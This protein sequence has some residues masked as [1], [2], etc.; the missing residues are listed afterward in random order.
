MTHFKHTFWQKRWFAAALAV[1]LLLVAGCSAGSGNASKD[2]AAAPA[3]SEVTAAEPIDT[4]RAA[5][6]PTESTPADEAPAAE[7]PVAEPAETPPR[8]NGMISL[9]QARL[10][11][12]L[13]SIVQQNIVNT[14]TDLDEDAELVRFVFGYRKTNNPTSILEQNDDEKAC[15]TLTIEQVNETLT[16]LFGKSISPDREDYSI[17]IDESEG[18]HCFYRD[19]V[20]WNVPPYPTERYPFPIRFALVSRIDEETFTLHFRL[21][22]VNPWIWG[23]DETERHL[24]VLPHMSFTDAEGSSVISFLGEGDAILHDFGEKLQLIKMV[25]SVT[26]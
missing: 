19:G 16:V 6:E 20:F 7:E 17:I 9:E 14:Q 15:R 2:S 1:V 11:C 21:Y 26:R 5:E 22:Q 25:G 23:E 13:T 12:F 8:P 24:G 10:N 18:F 4:S 3:A